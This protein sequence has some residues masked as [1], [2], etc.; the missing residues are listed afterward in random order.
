MQLQPVPT[1][2][3]DPAVCLICCWTLSCS[4][5]LLLL[6]HQVDLAAGAMLEQIDLEDPAA[7]SGGDIVV[8][9]VYDHKNKTLVGVLPGV[10]IVAPCVALKWSSILQMWT[11]HYTPL[12]FLFTALPCR[13][14]TCSVALPPLAR[15]AGHRAHAAP[16]Q[17]DIGQM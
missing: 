11:T 12:K 6:P 15:L 9:M 16:A 5:L 4:L 7:G 14:L 8:G 13:R 17:P 1:L 3:C 2:N 10:R